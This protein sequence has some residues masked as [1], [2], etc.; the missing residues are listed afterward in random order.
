MQII[1]TM[2]TEETQSDDMSSKLVTHTFQMST[3][4]ER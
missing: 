4:S 3:T 2:V 1:K